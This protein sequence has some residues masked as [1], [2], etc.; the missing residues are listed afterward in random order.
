M[1]L[2]TREYTAQTGRIIKAAQSGRLPRK[3]NVRM[4]ER[5]RLRMPP[6]VM[7]PDCVRSFLIAAI[8]RLMSGL[9]QSNR[10][11]ANEDFM[12]KQG[13]VS[14]VHRKKSHL[15]P[16][17]QHNQRSNVRKSVIRSRV[18]H[19]F[20]NQ[21]S[22][23]G[24][25]I[26]TVRH[27]PGHN[28]EQAGQ[29]RLQY[30]LLPLHGANQRHSIA[31]QRMQPSDQLETQIKCHHGNHQSKHQ[32]PNIQKKAHQSMVLR[33]LQMYKLKVYYEYFSITSPI[34]FVVYRK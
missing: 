10:S 9:T 8:R 29:Y 2:E 5:S 16:M 13:F 20:A 23:T 7:V 14:E 6:P 11:K 25:F 18:E 12:E 4:T 26:Q 24:L 19:V 34:S 1:E 31:I 27:R 32:K 33:F 30:A 3:Q 21:K 17:L 22:Q 15:K 28:E